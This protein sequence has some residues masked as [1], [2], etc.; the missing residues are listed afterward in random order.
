MIELERI[1]ED[2]ISFYKEYERAF[3]IEFK[4]YQSR[5]YPKESSDIIQ[6]YHI[7]SGNRY[8]GAI[9]LEQN[10]MACCKLKYIIYQKPLTN[11]P[12]I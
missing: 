10:L 11:T 12:L 4:K 6:W 1:D 7:K 9:W 8:I 2:N 5:I 3:D